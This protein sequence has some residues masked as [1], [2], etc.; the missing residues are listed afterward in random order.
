[1][2]K[3]LFLKSLLIAIGLLVTSLTTQVWANYAYLDLTAF[4]NWYGDGAKFRVDKN[5]TANVD[6]YSE[7][8][9]GGSG[10]GVW[11]FNIGDYT[12]SVTYKR[13]SSDYKSEWNYFN[14][15][16]SET[17]NVAHITGYSGSGNMQTSFVIN[18]IH[19]TNYVY[20][21]NSVSQFPNNIYF[22]IGKDYSPSGSS[23]AYSKAY[24]MSK[25]SN[26]NNLW[27]ISVTDTWED[28]TYFAI[29]A[30]DAASIS[31]GSWGSS[32]LGTTNKGDKG[33][34]AAYKKVYNMEGGSYLITTASS[35]NGQAITI[36]YKDGYSALNTTHTLNQTLSVNGG[37]AYSSSTKSISSAL[38]ISSNKMNNNGSTTSSSGSISSGSSSTTCDAARTATVSFS[39]T[40]KT[41][42]TFVGW[43]ESSTQKSTSTTWSFT[44][45]ASS[46]TITARFKANQ[47]AI[48]LNLNG[49]GNQAGK[50][51]TTSITATYNETAT[52]IAAGNL[53][54]KSGYGFDGYW[55]ES[56]GTGTQV[57]NERGEWIASV[58][59]YTDANKKWTCTSTHTLYARWRATG[60]YVVGEFNSWK[61]ESSNRID[62]ETNKASVTISKSPFA[63]SDYIAKFKI[64]QIN[65]TPNTDTWYGYGTGGTYTTIGKGSPTSAT[66]QTGNKNEIKLQVYYDGEYVFTF[67]S[68]T[69]NVTVKVPVIEQIQ[70]YEPSE[71]ARKGNYDWTGTPATYQRS[72]TI[73]LDR[74]TYQFKAVADSRFF[75]KSSGAISRNTASV[76][77]LTCTGSEGNLSITADLKGDYVFLLDTNPSNRRIAVTYPTRR[78]VTYSIVT[79]GGGTG[80]AGSL[81]ARNDDD[82]NVNISTLSNYV[83]DGNHVTFTAPTEATGY[84]WRGWYSTDTPNPASWSTNRLST[85]KTYSGVTVS[86]G[87]YTIY[88]VYSQDEYNTT[89]AVAP[90]GTKATT[91]PA[92][93][94]VAIKQITGTAIT[95]SAATDSIFEDWTISGGGLAFK[96]PSASTSNPATFT[97]TST[98]GTI[99][100]NF[101]PRWTIAGTWTTPTWK[102][103]K[104][105]A[106]LTGYTTVSTKKYATV[107]ISLAANTTYEFKVK[108]RSSSAASSWW[109]VSSATTFTYESHDYVQL[110]NVE[111]NKNITL[112][113]AAAGDYTFHF[114]LT[115]KKVSV[116]YPTSHKI[117]YGGYKTVYLEGAD[118]TTDGGTMRAVVSEVTINSGDYVSDGVTVNFYADETAGY[119]P[120]GWF[121][122]ADYADEHRYKRT[123]PNVTL[124]SDEGLLQLKNVSEAKTLYLR[125]KENKLSVGVSPY[126]GK[127]EV[128]DIDG[129]EVL[130]TIDVSNFVEVGVHTG[131]KL[132]V[133]PDVPYYFYGWELPESPKFT[134]GADHGENATTV[135]LYATSANIYDGGYTSLY[136]NCKIL[137]AIYFRNEKEDHTALWDSVY[138]G[139]NATWSDESAGDAGGK[140]G[141]STQGKTVLPMEKIYGN[142]WRVYIPRAITK[143]EYHKVAFFDKGKMQNWNQFYENNA[144]YRTDFDVNNNG[145]LNM[146]VPYHVKS[147]TD[148]KTTYYNTGY[149]KTAFSN[150][151]DAGYYLEHR[152]NTNQYSRV[153]T[154]VS[155]G[156]NKISYTLRLDNTSYK[157][158]AIYDAN[159]QRHVA[160]SGVTSSNYTDIQV[161]MDNTSDSKFGLTPTAEGNYVFVL[162]QSGDQM[163]LSVEF[164]VAV[165]D[166]VI[167]NAFNDGSAK[168]T[169]SNIIKASDAATKTR[170]SMYLNNAGS[171]T[172]KLRKCTSMAGGTPV[173][174]DGDGTNLQAILDNAKFTKGV[175]QFDITIAGDQVA[176]I[177]S[178]R[179]YTGNFYIKTDAADGGWVHY[180]R[181][182]LE[183]NT[184]NFDRNK[185]ETYDNYMCK[186]FAS[187]ECNIKSVIANDYCNQLSDTV[188]GDGIARMS[189]IEPYVP[190]DGTSIRFSYNSATNE[191]KRAYLGASANNDFLNIYPSTDDKIYRTV[192]ATEYDLFDIRT[193][194]KG[195]CKFAD[196][197]NFVYEMDVKVK[198]SGKA[199]VTATYT[200]ASSKAH[201]QT[202]VADTNTV[203]GG[204]SSSANKY[205]IRIVYDFKTN[206]MMSSFVLTE[207]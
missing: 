49:G 192:D 105:S 146:Y 31:A 13:M 81:T 131:K 38:S 35:G 44:D 167:E 130:E 66:L 193:S 107:T 136:A 19:G 80:T 202:L 165:N 69:P 21:D 7:V 50:T 172:L 113:S 201:V 206:Y 104:T 26:T 84:T 96:S 147:S 187:K 39:V 25:V 181:N 22:I 9:S 41:G 89:V 190:T 149:W 134:I 53:P 11:R 102:S 32:S 23:S 77:G 93:G 78:L 194:D 55:T 17:Q 191:T 71:S 52:N 16:I 10:T 116:D 125:Y 175:Y 37:G 133:I 122:N 67:N 88:A 114:N 180:K 128:Y 129:D 14:G 184:V 145:I 174:S 12:G 138:V 103:D 197:G 186:Y 126:L 58:D 79:V 24:K 29:V 123:D 142:T 161:N 33:Y 141:A 139:F 153:G 64:R 163:K 73:T 168:T 140:K 20:F 3:H 169:R 68:G 110:T 177:D 164:P 46:R 176:T 36:D 30:D 199:G 205:S 144:V 156:D 189:G 18:Y 188:R 2:K 203:L 109:G 207:W 204:S 56:G 98:G 74:E 151:V 97:A 48:T 86:G 51:A 137:N 101:T 166:Y 91:S 92:A 59:G 112:R 85:N 178:V 4:T 83:V 179:L 100:A 127:V 159:N 106:L 196:N 111:G 90:A 148:N 72:V 94:T 162:D 8:Q 121:N 155:T 185:P 158:Y 157:D 108:D 120:D 195:K 171:G 47:Y 42:Y 61:A 75:S 143:A 40:Q 135:N 27:Y 54:I 15:S 62:D 118:G 57:I 70:I 160:V 34:T 65:A 173:W 43:Y 28:A 82:G 5:G 115:D 154:F 124:S 170:Y 76:T 119:H 152:Y 87:D 1:M 182:I 60:Y 6:S 63:S 117:T 45:A 200:D 198:P 132:K 95:A 99:T 183:K 150:S